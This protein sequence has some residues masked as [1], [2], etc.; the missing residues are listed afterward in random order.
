[1]LQDTQIQQHGF[2]T[3]EMQ[4]ALSSGSKRKD[5]QNGGT[6][7]GIQTRRII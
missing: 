5:A 7:Q 4:V 2:A 6:N 1:M 3:V